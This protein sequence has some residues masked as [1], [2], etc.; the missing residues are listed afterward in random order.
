[1]NPWHEIAGEG[2]PVVVGASLGGGV[3]LDVALARPD[4]VD[5]LV[6]VDASLPDH[7]WS[8]ALTL[9]NEEEEQAT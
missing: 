1:M 8:E 5:R 3:A 2:P 4:L 9:Y 7:E 6:L